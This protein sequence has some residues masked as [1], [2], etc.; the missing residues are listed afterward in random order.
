MFDLLIDFADNLAHSS[1]ILEHFMLQPQFNHTKNVWWG[2]D[3]WTNYIRPHRLLPT[4]YE[5]YKLSDI[6]TSLECFT[7]LYDGNQHGTQ[8]VFQSLTATSSYQNFDWWVHNLHQF[9][10]LF[11]ILWV[12][13]TRDVLIQGI[14]RPHRFSLE[15]FGMLYVLITMK[16]NMY[17]NHYLP[18]NLIK[19]CVYFRSSECWLFS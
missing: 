15:L 14:L 2:T 6:C 5:G 16:P 7:V 11:G 19:T 9:F 13:F 3:M 17:F 4:M 8:H 10:F 18:H 1:R 12:G